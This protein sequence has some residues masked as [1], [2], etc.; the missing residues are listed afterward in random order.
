M[1]GKV[2]DHGVLTVALYL[3]LGTQNDALLAGKDSVLGVGG[4]AVPNRY[5]WALIHVQHWFWHSPGGELDQ[6]AEEAGGK[7]SEWAMFKGSIVEASIMSCGQNVVMAAT[8]E[9]DGG[10][11][12]HLTECATTASQL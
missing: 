5:S 12:G 3:A 9:P 4:W 10:H 8:R 6:K 7:E 2:K 11:V 1:V